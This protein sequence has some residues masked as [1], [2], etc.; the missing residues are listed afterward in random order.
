[1]I[2][3]L[4]RF[5]HFAGRDLNS[6]MPVIE[7]YRRMYRVFEPIRATLVGRELR[8]SEIIEVLKALIHP[9]FRK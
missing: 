1:M 9:D 4:K 8:A 6:H 7:G 2:D 5:T 3:D